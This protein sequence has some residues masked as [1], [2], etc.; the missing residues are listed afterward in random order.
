MYCNN[1]WHTDFINQLTDLVV[2]KCY[3]Q[4]KVLIFLESHT[5]L[6]ISRPTI[7]E[8]TKAKYFYNYFMSI[9][10]YNS[11]M[12]FFDHL[13]FFS[14][15]HTI[16]DQMNWQLFLIEIVV[17]GCKFPLYSFFGKLLFTTTLIR[18]YICMCLAFGNVGRFFQIL[19]SFLVYMNFSKL[20][21]LTCK[22]DT[23]GFSLDMSS[24][25][26]GDRFGNFFQTS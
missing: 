2:L 24:N 15:N 21:I 7:F 14:T 16:A 22:Q 1:I 12:E 4:S 9:V 11:A 8:L 25:E 5:N 18:K 13:H 6:I 19:V 23:L 10:V 3:D 17:E 26:I 20:H